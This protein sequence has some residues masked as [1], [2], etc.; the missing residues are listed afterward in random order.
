MLPKTIS[1]KF[2]FEGIGLHTGQNVKVEVRPSM[3]NEIN[4]WVCGSR[5]EF[6]IDNVVSTNLATSLSNSKETILT[7][8]HFMSIVYMLGITSLDILVDG[9]EI[10]IMDGSALKFYEMFLKVG[11]EDLPFLTSVLRVKEKIRV[12]DSDT[13]AYIE[14]LPAEKLSIQYHMKYNHPMLDDISFKTP[15]TLDT[16]L[17]N[18]V[19]CR[20]FCFEKD[21]EE[22]RAQ[23]LIKGGSLDN[24]V[25]MTKDS[26][27][28]ELRFPD[29]MV[30]HK[31]LDIIGDMSLLKYSLVGEIRAHLSGHKLNVELVKK[32]H[33]SLDI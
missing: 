20:T 31:I 8:E 13:D 33:E 30:R 21:L 3:S 2:H 5:I 16:Y 27:L 26:S 15:I 11:L 23:G 10:P 22:M 4:F 6:N 14:I 9:T 17:S 28:N 25:V 32:I 18:I 24:A 7:V 19:A 29:E 12:E 1:R